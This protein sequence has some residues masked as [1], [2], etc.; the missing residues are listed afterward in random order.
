MSQL[1]APAM[2]ASYLVSPQF[3]MKRLRAEGAA[4]EG[5]GGRVDDDE[6]VPE[7]QPAEPHVR[8]LGQPP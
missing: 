4:D 2:P 3:E 1:V 7:Q 5:L 6:G 8:D